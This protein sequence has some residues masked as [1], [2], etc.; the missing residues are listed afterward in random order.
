MSRWGEA[1][2]PDEAYS[3][4]TDPT[5]FAPLHALSAALLDDLEARYQVTRD[6]STEPD[7]HAPGATAPAVRLTPADPEAAPLTVVTTAFPGLIVRLGDQILTLPECGCDACDET[8]PDLTEVLHRHVEALVAGTFGDRLVHDESRSFPASYR[9]SDGL[10][11]VH[12]AQWWHEQWYRA[13]DGTEGASRTLLDKDQLAELRKALPTGE[14][15]WHP[16]PP[17]A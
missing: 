12:S 1:G 15:T 4:V 2:P 13:A 16:W 3:R 17:N 5:R 9:D 8:I 11:E 10:A 6:T 14:R 7:P